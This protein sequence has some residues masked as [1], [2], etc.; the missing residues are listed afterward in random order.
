M[1][2]SAC[3]VSRL[4]GGD[5]CDTRKKTLKM[6]RDVGMACQKLCKQGRDDALSKDQCIGKT[7]SL[8]PFHTTVR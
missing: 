8:H 2:I 5:P 4:C 7:P 6:E 3:N 1:C